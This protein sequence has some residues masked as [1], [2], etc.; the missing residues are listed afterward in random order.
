MGSQLLEDENSH[1]EAPA[2]S[3]RDSRDNH[4]SQMSDFD[5]F[6]DTGQMA[7]GSE[8]GFKPPTY[9]CILK[10]KTNVSKCLQSD[11]VYSGGGERQL[12]EDSA[13]SSSFPKK[14]LR[15]GNQSRTSVI[16]K[17]LIQMFS[18]KQ[19]AAKAYPVSGSGYHLFQ[20]LP[21][22]LQSRGCILPEDV[23]AYLDSIWP[24][25]TKCIMVISWN[26]NPHPQINQ[27]WS[28]AGDPPLVEKAR[29][30]LEKGAISM[31]DSL[32]PNLSA[33]ALEVLEATLKPSSQNSYASKW[34]TFA[35]CASEQEMALIQFHPSLTKG[36]SPYNMLYSYLNNK[37]RY[38]IVDSNGVEMFM[39][40]LAAYQPVPSKFHPLGGQGLDPCHPSLLLG[41]I[42][43]KRPPTGPDLL[44]KTKRKSVTFKDSIEIQYLSQMPPPPP[45]SLSDPLCGHECLTAILPR[46]EPLLSEEEPV[47]KMVHDSLSSLHQ[48]MAGGG[49]S[50]SLS[51][52]ILQL[53][54]DWPWIEGHSGN[55]TLKTLG[56]QSQRDRICTSPGP[57]QL[58]NPL[59]LHLP[60]EI[61]CPNNHGVDGIH[62]ADLLD[63][64]CLLNVL[65]PEP[66]LP[67]EA[68][69]APLA[70]Q[71]PVAGDTNS[72]VEETLSLIQYVTQLQSHITPVQEPPPS[73]L[74]QPFSVMPPEMTS[75]LSPVVARL[76]FPAVQQS[77][78]EVH[79]QL[80]LLLSS[81]GGQT[82]PS[83]T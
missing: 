46:C 13:I 44:P 38:G 78:D 66:L 57:V 21:D 67:A 25:N 22:L 55:Q 19:F 2:A 59:G 7:A 32:N 37:Q 53:Q 65:C 79:A 80:Q 29:T 60:S 15:V 48:K 23:W 20:A 30:L 77:D 69:E 56:V 51:D 10:Q 40:P 61:V 18:L 35:T 45:L 28:S 68:S 8:G 36:C 16:W 52:V 26:S 63:A 6:S 27:L 72:L 58:E 9:K 12:Q 4:K 49:T 81:L 75:A 43:P 11:T 24:A 71:I 34:N 39:V 47:S 54:Y 5:C 76:E 14:R 41:L 42:L 50:Q 62:G 82:Q 1:L 70:P 17:G 31:V 33:S 73:L 74:L 3:M 83:S 64:S